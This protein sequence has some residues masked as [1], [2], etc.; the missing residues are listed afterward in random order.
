[1]RQFLGSHLSYFSPLNLTTA[2]FCSFHNSDTTNHVPP[3]FRQTRKTC[4]GYS[5]FSSWW[6]KISKRLWRTRCFNSLWEP[7]SSTRIHLQRGQDNRW[8]TWIRY[9]RKFRAPT[10]GRAIERAH[11]H[12]RNNRF[13][14]Y[15]PT[16]FSPSCYD[17][18]RT[19]RN[20]SEWLY[21][22]N[23]PTW[24]FTT[25]N[26]Y[27]ILTNQCILVIASTACIIEGGLLISF[28]C[29]SIY[30]N[31]ISRQ[32]T[33]KFLVELLSLRLTTIS[34]EVWTLWLRSSI[35]ENTEIHVFP[36]RE[37]LTISPKREYRVQKH[38]W[39]DCDPTSRHVPRQGNRAP[40]NRYNSP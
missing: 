29:L 17:P 21:L 30:I 14:N 4:C 12:R 28:V 13:C 18:Y 16:P 2:V 15:A 22:C 7:S 1:M 20:C 11:R 19:C 3:P 34:Q 25:G 40:R 23:C 32:P 33:E 24:W 6:K 35:G 31:I 5:H 8:W 27:R 37:K 9:R 38:L 10:T 26:L 36:Y 39:F